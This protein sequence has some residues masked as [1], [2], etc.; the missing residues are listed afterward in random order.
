MPNLRLM[1]LT[2]TLKKI[3][4]SLITVKDI[5]KDIFAFLAILLIGSGAFMI[6][7]ISVGETE[8][9]NELKI[10]SASNALASVGQADYEANL[11]SKEQGFASTSSNSLRSYT[12]RHQSTNSQA[13]SGM[14][15]GS[16]NGRVYHLPSCP[17]AKRIKDEN[18]VWFKDKKDAADH[19]YKPA[20]NC[21]GI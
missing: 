12:S 2:E 17:G 19:G 10:V 13:K 5:P 15:V 11:S 4:T 16:K 21:K 3:N 9:K 6:G 20:A 8:R 7:R 14:Y 1:R 18:K